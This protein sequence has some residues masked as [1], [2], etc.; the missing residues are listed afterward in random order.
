MML[1]RVR[2]SVC[3]LEK[4]LRKEVEKSESEEDDVSSVEEG[5]EEED[6]GG[7]DEDQQASEG[8][9]TSED[10]DQDQGDGGEA[11]RVYIFQK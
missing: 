4:K 10:Q 2:C 9:G 3:L 7:S 1:T 6:Q 5:S 11:K 8:E